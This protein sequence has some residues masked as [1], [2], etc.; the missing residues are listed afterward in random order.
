MGIVKTNEETGKLEEPWEAVEVRVAEE[1]SGT[2]IELLNSRKGELTDMGLDDGMSVVKYLIP[3]RGMLG[4]RSNLLSATR[5]T[6]IIDSVFDSYRPQ[7]KGDLI[8]RDK[9]S[10][11]AFADGTVTTF[12]L[13]GAQDRGKLFATPGDEVYKG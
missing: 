5:G 8:T 3:T 2:V 7:I 12:G 10:L 4:L 9:G 11:L 13:E 1:F 6:V